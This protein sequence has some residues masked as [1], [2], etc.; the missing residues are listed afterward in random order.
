MVSINTDK[1]DRS[2]GVLRCSTQSLVLATK[3]GKGCQHKDRKSVNSSKAYAPCF[4][5]P[6]AKA[7]YG[8]SPDVTKSLIRGLSIHLRGPSTSTNI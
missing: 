6:F 4:E 1:P 5:G 8:P 7:T 3:A 2:T